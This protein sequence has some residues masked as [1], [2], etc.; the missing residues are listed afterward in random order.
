MFRRKPTLS[1]VL[2]FIRQAD[3]SQ[4]STIIQA[5]VSRYGEVYPDWDVTFLSLP[6]NDPEE[7]KNIIDYF[8]KF[9]NM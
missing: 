7:R 9:V 4:I 5:L 8:L 6:K 1:K 2:E 3:D